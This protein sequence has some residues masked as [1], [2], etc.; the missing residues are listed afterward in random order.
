M[1]KLLVL[2]EKRI[3]PASLYD[4]PRGLG[5]PPQRGNW[6]PSQPFRTHTLTNHGLQKRDTA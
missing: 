4:T 2:A 5:H 1:T 3:L 6:R